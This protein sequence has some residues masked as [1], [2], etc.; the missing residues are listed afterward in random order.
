MKRLL[1]LVLAL[2]YVLIAVGCRKQQPDKHDPSSNQAESGQFAF[3]YRMEKKAYQAGE[4]V[5]I[6]ATVTNISGRDYVYTGSYSE[7]SPEA[8]LYYLSD[9]NEKLGYIEHEPQ[10]MTNDMNRHVIANGESRTAT[11]HF[12]LPEGVE[13]TEYSIT[14]SY[15]GEKREFVNVLYVFSSSD[16]TPYKVEFAGNYDIINDIKETYSAGEKVLIQLGTITEHYYVVYVNGVSLSP[17]ETVSDDRTF[18]YYTFV[19]PNKNVMIKI[20]DRY[21]DIPLAP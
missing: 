14:L 3:S 12:V 4:C 18:T 2:L 21:V 5:E 9:D 11:Y 20:E 16:E 13:H 10:P 17:D 19:M 7:F 1:V 6:K 8:S 15:K